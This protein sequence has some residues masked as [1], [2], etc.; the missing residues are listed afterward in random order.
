M[1]VKPFSLRR[2][3]SHTIKEGEF[4][5]VDVQGRRVSWLKGAKLS[6][7]PFRSRLHTD[8]YVKKRARPQLQIRASVSTNWETEQHMELLY[9]QSTHT[10]PETPVY[11][12]SVTPRHWRFRRSAAPTGHVRTYITYCVRN[13][14]VAPYLVCACFYSHPGEDLFT[15]SP[16]RE[17]YCDYFP[18]RMRIV[19]QQRTDPKGRTRA[20]EEKKS[21]TQ[22]F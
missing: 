6:M 22:Q 9:L 12:M 13:V 1:L 7:V 21:K 8:F 2:L 14:G 5:G 11:T 19:D 20:S 15:K 10:T 18:A 16:L 4:D 3:C 17:F